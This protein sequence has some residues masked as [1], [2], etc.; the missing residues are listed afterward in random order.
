MPDERKVLGR[1]GQMLVAIPARARRALGLVPGLSVWFHY[2][3]TGEVLLG[4]R[5]ERVGGRPPADLP[6]PRCESR[7]RELAELR[8]RLDSRE[9]GAARQYFAQGYEQAVR[10]HGALAVKLDAA[11][12]FLRELTGRAPGKSGRSKRR[13][14]RWVGNAPA[15]P[16]EV[17]DAPVLIAPDGESIEDGSGAS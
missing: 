17:V 12:D 10:H 15:R 3:R 2:P 7:E 1:R 16:V 4:I 5:E 6:C 8:A 13:E 9:G 14:R 11:L